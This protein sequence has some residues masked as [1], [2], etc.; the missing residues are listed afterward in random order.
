MRSS[1][2][3]DSASSL[4]SYASSSKP[5]QLL[6]VGSCL[7]A[8][9]LLEFVILVRFVEQNIL[10]RQWDR[11]CRPKFFEL[12]ICCGPQENTHQGYT[13]QSTELSSLLHI[14]VST[15]VFDLPKLHFARR[16]GEKNLLPLPHQPFETL[17][18]F[19]RREQRFSK[20]HCLYWLHETPCMGKGL[21]EAKIGSDYNR[22]R[23][24]TLPPP[25][26]DTARPY[27][28]GIFQG[29]LVPSDAARRGASDASWRPVILAARL[30]PYYGLVLWF[31]TRPALPANTE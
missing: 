18:S 13:C 17:K 31:L 10:Y 2:V 16:H 5:L 29:A 6:Y 9:A 8:K 24:P 14:C 12:R 26:L 27:F 25:T 1:L 4:A 7:R 3:R 21:Q 28:A 23:V 20:C 19:E 11:H 22:E 15:V 30:I